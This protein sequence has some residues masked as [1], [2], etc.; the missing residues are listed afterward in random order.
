MTNFLSGNV[1]K[2]FYLDG[3]IVKDVTL[4][5]V[6]VTTIALNLTVLWLE[7]HIKN[8]SNSVIWF[9]SMNPLV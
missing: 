2:R 9:E 8:N 5:F 6:N 4:P 1:D 7:E 3:N